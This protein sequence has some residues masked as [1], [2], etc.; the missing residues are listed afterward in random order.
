[1]ISSIQDLSTIKAAYE[2]KMGRYKY[3]ALVCFGT[4]CTSSGCKDIRD[5]LLQEIEKYG[6]Q[7]EVAVI[8]RGC[9]GTCA[10][11]PVVYVLPDET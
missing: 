5:T 10:V 8:E 9:M 3:Q 11:G 7:D 2:E 4:G 1:M 6:L